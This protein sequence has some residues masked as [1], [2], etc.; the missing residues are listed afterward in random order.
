MQGSELQGQEIQNSSSRSGAL[1]FPLLVSQINVFYWSGQP[2][3][4]VFDSECIQWYSVLWRLMTPS[5]ESII[6]K[7]MPHLCIQQTVARAIRLV[8]S[9]RCK[10]WEKQWLSGPCAPS[11]APIDVS[12]HRGLLQCLAV[13]YSSDQRLHKHCLAEAVWVGKVNPY[14]NVCQFQS[15]PNKMND[16]VEGFIEINLYIKKLIAASRVGAHKKRMKC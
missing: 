14:Q 11:L 15:I 13:F 1:L 12:D 7:L 16:N 3:I 5:P 6:S 9:G 8:A 10:M 4:M 2:H